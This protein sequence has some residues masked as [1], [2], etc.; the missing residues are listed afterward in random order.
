MHAAELG[1]SVP[2]GEPFWFIKPS[3][4]YLRADRQSSAHV[5]LPRTAVVHHEVELAAVIGTPISPCDRVTANDAMKHVK[6]YVCAVDI[7]ARNWQNDAKKLGRPWAL[8][9]GC[10]TFLP[11]SQFVPAENVPDPHNLQLWLD[12]NGTRK[13]YA[14]TSDMLFSLPSL[15]EHVAK[16]VTL[17]EWDLLLTGTPHGVGPIVPGDHVTAGIQQLTELHFRCDSAPF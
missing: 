3:T 12:V 8:S 13:Q 16:Y 2:V 5:L 15:I 9:K 1:S 4:S 17:Q 6:G 14:S 7:T 11:L 10:D